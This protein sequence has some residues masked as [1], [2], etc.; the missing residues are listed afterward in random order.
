MSIRYK[1]TQDIE[2]LHHNRLH[3]LLRVFY[4]AAYYGH[5]DFVRDY[6]ILLMRISPFIKA[7]NKQSI[8]SGAI[9]GERVSVVRMLAKFRYMYK[10]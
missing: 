6:M 10:D 7:Y 3:F 8:L 1:E 5:L 4:W 9:K 2:G